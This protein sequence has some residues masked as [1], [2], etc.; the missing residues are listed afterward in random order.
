M[1]DQ[2]F[3]KTALDLVKK[4]FVI[5]IATITSEIVIY[6]AHKAQIAL[7]K[8]EKTSINV[9]AKYSDFANVFSKKLGAMLPKD[10]KINTHNMN[11]EES[12]QLPFG[13]IY[14][15]GPVELETL[16]TYIKTNLV[17]SF[18]HLSKFPAGALI[19]FN[20][21]PNNRNLCL[22]VSYPGFNDLIIKNQYPILLIG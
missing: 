3:A 14:E 18:I 20:Q 15:L 12:K 7:L 1:I 8:A 6:L 22:Y 21:K 2:K 9:P 11:L 17:N 19:L 13:A 4:V 16:K 5:Y 10:T